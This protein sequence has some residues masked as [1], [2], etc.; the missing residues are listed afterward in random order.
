MHKNGKVKL[1]ITGGSGFLARGVLESCSQAG[2]SC[3]ALS[4][5]N[6]PPWATQAIDWVTIPSYNDVSALS[7]ALWDTE[8][9]LHLAD[10]P[11]RQ[12]SS[13]SLLEAGERSDKL[14]AAATNCNM[15]GCIVA[16][17]VY[18]DEFGGRKLSSYGLTKRVIEQRFLD[19][20]DLQTLIL[21]LPPVYGPG[22]KGGFTALSKLVRRKTLLPLGSVTAPRAYLS[23]RNFSSLI[24]ALVQSEDSAWKNAAGKIFEPSD[25][26]AVSTQDLV[27]KM[28][29]V[30]GVTARLVPVPVA[31]LRV[32]AA[33]TGKTEIAMAATNEL[34]VAPVEDIE[35]VFGWRPVE[36]MPR[37]LAYLRDEI[38]HP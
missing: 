26:V 13:R 37:S 10:D 33:L 35:D 15:K 2:L 12:G 36:C 23:R 11:A 17:S 38:S 21:R 27:H 30:M 28:A 29:D 20:S 8:Y 6:R 5:S 7:S 31:L 14:I 1:A 9:V 24:I 4:R 18:A 16:S 32:V 3:R 19:A 22:G 25:G 34:K